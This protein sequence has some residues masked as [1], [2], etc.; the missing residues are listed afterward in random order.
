MKVLEDNVEKSL[1]REEQSLDDDASSNFVDVASLQKAL[2]ALKL[3]FEVWWLSSPA[4]L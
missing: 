4:H 2:R 1:L 3:R